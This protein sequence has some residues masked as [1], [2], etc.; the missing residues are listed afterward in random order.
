[1]IH[2]MPF[3]GFVAVIAIVLVIATI[4]RPRLPEIFQP[5]FTGFVMLVCLLVFLDMGINS[6]FI[7]LKG[8]FEIAFNF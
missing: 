6:V 5:F 7:A 4:V 2:L 8:A 3:F 1:M